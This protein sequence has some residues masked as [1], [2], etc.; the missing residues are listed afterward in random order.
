[1]AYRAFYKRSEVK[2]N[3]PRICQKLFAG[4]AKLKRSTITLFHRSLPMRER[5][6]RATMNERRI[7]TN[8][9]ELSF[10]DAESG[11][12]KPSRPARVAEESRPIL[13]EAGT[14]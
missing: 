5:M 2:T 9:T 6:I 13:L 3:R 4:R 7:D 10:I 8:S 1:M 14:L 11:L 12:T